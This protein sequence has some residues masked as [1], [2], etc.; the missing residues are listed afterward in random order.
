M[1][2]SSYPALIKN[3]KKYDK[4][5]FLIKDYAVVI[6]DNYLKIVNYDGNVL[7]KYDNMSNYSLNYDASGWKK[8]D[9]KE[10]IYLV[11]LNEK[12]EEK[13]YYYVPKS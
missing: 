5:C 3:S 12:N 9:D 8:I 1:G 13:E 7:A 11:I 6:D 10:G 2:L 4:V